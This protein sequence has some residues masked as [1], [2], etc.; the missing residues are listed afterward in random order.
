MTICPGAKDPGRWDRD[1]GRDLD[2]LKQHHAADTLVTLLE[3]EEFERYG[4]PDLLERAR[5]VGLEVVH[6]PITDVSTPRKAQSDEYA[7]LVERIVDLL[8]DRKTVLIHCRGGLG[9]TGTVAASVLVALGHTADEAIGI[10]RR[11]RS[12]RAV[13]TSEQ[14]EYVRRFEEE[15]RASHATGPS[16]GSRAHWWEPTQIERYRGCLLGLAL[17]DALGTTLEF[18]PPGTFRPIVDMVG[19]GPFGLRAGKWTDDTSMALCLAESLIEKRG[20]DPADQLARYVRWYREGH[21]SSTGECFD[22]GNATREALERFEQTGES[23]AGSRDPHWAGTGSIMRLAPVPLF[24]ARGPLGLSEDDKPVEAIEGCGESSRT[25]HGAQNCVDACRYLGALIVGAI[26]GASK[27]DLLSENY[28]PV[29]GYWEKQPLSEEVSEVAAGSFKRKQP[30]EIQGRGYVI[31]SLEAA[32]WAFHNTD[33]F[34]EGALLAV[35]LGDDADTTGAVYGQLAGACY[36]ERSIPESW[37][38][39]LAHRLLIEQLAEQL[40][41][42]GETLDWE[43]LLSFLP[44]FKRPGFEFSCEVRSPGYTLT[45]QD[46]TIGPIPYYDWA[47]E[48]GEFHKTL[49]DAGVIF[50]F[51]WMGWREAE[52]YINDPTAL[53]SAD[54]STLR[55]LLSLHAR[56]DRFNEGHFVEM[57]KSGHMTA[58]LRCARELWEERKR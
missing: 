11:V 2:E 10:V 43:M 40:F 50:I 1:L 42:L 58:V 52:R 27:E 47:L 36:G 49:Y 29:S 24:Y 53:R 8:R 56:A 26:N 20:F 46:G 17:G 7:A 31:A 22:I 35:N 44:S 41:R 19:G 38:R 57:F 37:K 45:L 13:E 4:V 6:F 33:S 32:L 54:E 16:P 30:P 3:R 28:C 15:W 5:E 18:K 55:R 12:E 39:K 25:T 14:E 34:K 9:R 51:D 48:V 21:M 23:Y